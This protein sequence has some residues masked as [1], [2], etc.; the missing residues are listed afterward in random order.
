MRLFTLSLFIAPVL[1][2][3]IPSP[4]EPLQPPMPNTMIGVGFSWQRG[5]SYPLTENTMFAKNFSV[6]N[7]R[8]QEKIPTGWWLWTEA[9]TPIAPQP[10]KNQPLQSSLSAGIAYMAAQTPGGEVSMV[11]IATGGLS[12]SQASA[13]GTFSGNLGFAFRLGSNS[14]WYIMPYIGGSSLVGS[15]ASGTFTIQPGAML[16]YGFRGGK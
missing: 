3:Q 11:L 5:A 7:P 14:N 16:M 9:S 10:L 8:T 1:C 12:A 6:T 4:V 15:A 2:A 13:G